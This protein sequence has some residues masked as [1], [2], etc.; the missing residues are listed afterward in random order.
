MRVHLWL[1]CLAFLAVQA[2][3]GRAERHIITVY[4]PHGK[5]LLGDCEQRFEAANPDVDVRWLDMGSQEI[6]DRLRAESR[7]PRCD[8]WFGAPATLFLLAASE[9][10]L[11][12]YRPSW[13][14]AVV[15]QAHDREH[16]WYGTFLTPEVILYNRDRIPREQAPRSFRELWE[17]PFRGRVVL[18]EPVASGT[19]LAIFGAIVQSAPT[20]RE[21]LRLLA[22]LDVATAQY[23]KNPTLL[24][25]SLARG[26]ADLT[27]WNL[28]DAM[29]Q[30]E[31]YG[32]PFDHVIPAVGTPVLI[33]AIAIVA[34]APQP[35]AAERFYEFVTG[36]EMAT[37]LAHTYYR[38][39]A[40][41]DVP[42][43]ALPEWMRTPIPAL[44]MDWPRLAAQGP[45]W[46]NEF[47]TRIKGRGAEY[48]RETQ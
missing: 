14:E 3:P 18:R 6:L 12:P 43:S 41:S 40:R 46:M 9:G 11:A 13:A 7:R 44:P 48:L 10:L 30:R 33:D 31:K 45:R 17:E 47:D 8:V 28:P 24:F 32:F 21:G 19:M 37:H 29:L 26:S 39:P 23:A 38:I 16:L 2:S 27:L 22:Q 20:E 5:E 34:G 1:S 42:A 36:M 15:E 25:L 4:S 35:P